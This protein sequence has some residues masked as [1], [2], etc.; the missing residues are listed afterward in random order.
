M[1]RQRLLLLLLL[2]F[3]DGI[4]GNIEDLIADCTDFRR[5]QCAQGVTGGRP[6]LAFVTNTKINTICIGVLIND[7]YVISTTECAAGLD[8]NAINPEVLVSFENSEEEFDVSQIFLHPNH[9]PDSLPRLYDIMLVRLALLVD[10]TKHIPI[11][12]PH[13]SLLVYNGIPGWIMAPGLRP[14]SVKIHTGSCSF[15]RQVGGVVR[16]I[17]VR[18][19]MFLCVGNVKTSFCYTHPGYL[20]M[21]MVHG[22]YMLLGLSSTNYLFPMCKYSQGL[23]SEVLPYRAWI[24]NITSD[25]SNCQFVN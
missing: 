10:M 13:A 7:R 20:L 3:L 21:M 16:T 9:V 14:L 5:C 11:C 23:F 19:G 1:H 6:A 25:S 8:H 17:R 18:P 12:L 4:L 22:W 2:S 24:R 15:M